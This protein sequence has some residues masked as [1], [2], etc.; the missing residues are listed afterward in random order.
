MRHEQ[1]YR[2]SVSVSQ[3]QSVSISTPIAIPIPLAIV[4]A[5]DVRM[6]A[7][8]SPH[9]NFR[10]CQTFVASPA[11]PGSLNGLAFKPNMPFSR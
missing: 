5:L 4:L 10:I 11:E 7:G 3:S 8:H 1:Y 2:G 9:N 6:N